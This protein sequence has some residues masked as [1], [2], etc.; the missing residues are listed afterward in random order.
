MSDD[1]TK[2]AAGA[3]PLQA[4]LMLPAIVVVIIA[5]IALNGVAG[6]SEFYAGFFFLLYWASFEH[7]KMSA[8]PSSALGCAFGLAMGFG[9]FWLTHTY[10]QSGG[11]IFMA[12]LLP[13]IFCLMIGFL[14]LI[15][16]NAAMLTLT[17]ATIPYVQEHADFG[18]M[19]LSLGLGV[20]FFGLLF[21]GVGKLTAPKAAPVAAAE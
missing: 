17:V 20:A 1:K 2:A 5:F 13:V 21:W 15:I 4:L 14:P 10:G 7:S 9:L 12:L 11:L 18:K 19:F 3:K 6:T 8:L 16:N